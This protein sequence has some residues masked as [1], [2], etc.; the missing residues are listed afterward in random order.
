[1]SDPCASPNNARKQLRAKRW[2][3]A[4]LI[5]GACVGLGAWAVE[6]IQDINARGG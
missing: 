6:K 3:I 2:T 5:A 4:V 1:M